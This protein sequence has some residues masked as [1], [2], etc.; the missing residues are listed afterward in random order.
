[1]PTLSKACARGIG[2]RRGARPWQRLALLALCAWLLVAQQQLRL[3]A[4]SHLG[5]EHA[6]AAAEP[7]TGHDPDPEPG[8]EADAC[9]MCLTAAAAAS[10]LAAAPG[11]VPGLARPWFAPAAAGVQA[12]RLASVPTRFIRGPPLRP[13]L[14]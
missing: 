7:G 6:T 14:G 8:H 9:A 3:H 5:G 2:L 4:Q 10:L 11:A 1:M 13:R 12:E